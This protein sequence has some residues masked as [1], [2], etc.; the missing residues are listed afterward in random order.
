MEIKKINKGYFFWVLL[1]FL[2]KAYSQEIRD[3]EPPIYPGC[4]NAEN[5]M[6]CMRENIIDL[7]AEN[8]QAEEQTGKQNKSIIVECTLSILADGNIEIN[9]INTSDMALKKEI[10]RIFQKLPSVT[11]AKQKGIPINIQYKIPLVFN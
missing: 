6:K 9:E 11:P 3:V 5:K 7:I 1:L 4:E 2:T 8:F 10:L